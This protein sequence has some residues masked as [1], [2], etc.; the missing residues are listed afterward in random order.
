MCA[1]PSED[2]DQTAH[3]RSLIQIF[4]GRILDSQ[5]YEVS[6]CGRRRLVRLRGCADWFEYTL[7]AHV[8]RYVFSSCS[9]IRLSPPVSIVGV[10]VS[11]PRVPRCCHERPL[12]TRPRYVGLQACMSATISGSQTVTKKKRV[13][14]S[15]KTLP[16]SN[17]AWNE[18]LPF[19]RKVTD[20]F[21]ISSTKHRF[22][23]RIISASAKRF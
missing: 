5:N 22:W 14:Q 1:K 23:V 20:I 17:K 8:R 9:P 2:S 3:S 16:S 6:S 4:T 7:S 15:R 18:A 11:L 10:H 13:I 12:V 21:L 19:T